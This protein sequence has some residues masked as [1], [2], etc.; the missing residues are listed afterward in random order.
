[1]TPLQ[2]RFNMWLDSRLDA[3][4]MNAI[5]A[6]LSIAIA[7]SADDALTIIASAALLDGLDVLPEI[8]EVT[9]GDLHDARYGKD[10]T[11]CD[12]G[13]P[14]ASPGGLCEECEKTST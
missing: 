3:D 6:V 12:C 11:E 14:S 13:K 5:G 7:T 4:D 9:A 8:G 2:E 10:D 1:M